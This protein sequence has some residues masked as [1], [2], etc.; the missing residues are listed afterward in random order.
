MTGVKIPYDQ[1][2]FGLAVQ[3]G[4]YFGMSAEEY[5]AIPALS[6]SG[7][8][9]ILCSPMN[10]WANTLWLNPEYEE[11]ESRF[12][13]MGKAYHSRIVEGRDAFYSR[14]APALDPDD[15]PDA[16]KTMEDLRSALPE[17]VKKGGNKTE[18]AARVLDHFPH[19]EIWDLMIEEYENQHEGKEFLSQNLIKKIEIAAAMIE[20]HPQLCKAFTGGYPEV[21]IVWN[22]RETGVP[23][24]ARLDYLKTRAIVDLKTFSN[25]FNKPVDR[26]IA[27]AVASY[28]LHI[29]VAVYHEAV[30]EAKAMLQ[31]AAN[32]GGI[33][34]MKATIHGDFDPAWIG[35]FAN[36]GFMK[37][38]PPRDPNEMLDDEELDDLPSESYRGGHE[39]LF[40]FQQTGVA[41][42]ARGWKFPRHLTYD[43]G[44]IA[45]AEAKRLFKENME[46]F[47]KDPWIDQTG[48]QE[49][50]D[51]AFPAFITE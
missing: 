10:F 24:K 1:T 4:I 33:D 32:T 30:E 9:Q 25:P 2:A 35:Q 42:V 12:M 11:E 41:P 8:K 17:G 51:S 16:L 36:C 46:R 3:P 44:K 15:Y 27:Y 45:V 38:I 5:H 7:V 43:I 40:V 47:G 28:K 20:K 26:A 39:F 23:M 18:L 49:F 21:S 50:D 22:C 19:A 6:N 48:I 34:A 31:A 13:D 14:Y 29:Q 37:P